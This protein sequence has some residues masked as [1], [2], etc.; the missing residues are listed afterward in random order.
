M[1]TA[2]MDYGPFRKGQS[3]RLIRQGFDWLLIK[4][5]GRLIYVPTF[6][7]QKDR[8]DAWTEAM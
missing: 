1:I 4:G 7:E 3:Y 8:D 6:I 2:G 5:C